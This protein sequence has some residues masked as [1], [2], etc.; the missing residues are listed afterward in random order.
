MAA[1]RPDRR[2]YASG[3]RRGDHDPPIR[4]RRSLFRDIR[5]AARSALPVGPAGSA[6]TKWKK[7]G[8]L[9]RSSRFFAH[10]RWS[11]RGALGCGSFPPIEKFNS[12][13]P[14]NKIIG[15]SHTGYA[16]CCDWHHEDATS[17]LNAFLDAAHA[18]VGANAPL[19]PAYTS[20]PINERRSARPHEN[21]ALSPLPA[22]EGEGLA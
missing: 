19:G 13:F 11:I 15:G 5:A 17:P 6:S 9:K 1:R 3:I 10:P 16:H 7:S 18:G 21:L 2:A 12:T 8:V 20:G 14:A 4:S 22:A